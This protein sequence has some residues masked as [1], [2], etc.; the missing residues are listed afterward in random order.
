MKELIEAMAKV[1]V[2]HPQA[3][4][5][6]VVAGEQTAVFELGVAPQDIGQVIGKQGHTAD[7]LRTIIQS[8]GTKHHKRYRLEILG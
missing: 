6:Q 2:D 1:L 3:V 5:V 8:V 7:A 4:R